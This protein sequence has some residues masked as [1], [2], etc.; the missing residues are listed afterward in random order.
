MHS[1]K[2]ALMGAF[3]ATLMPGNVAQLNAAPLPTDI[4]VM[5]S[6]A[7]DGTVQVRWGYGRG[8]WARSWERNQEPAAYAFEHYRPYSRLYRWRHWRL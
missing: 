7:A 2:L 6:R 3:A 4:A 8:S 1:F 5:K